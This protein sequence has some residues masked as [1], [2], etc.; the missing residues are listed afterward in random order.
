MKNRICVFDLETCNL[1]LDDTAP[2][3]IAAIILD[4]ESLEPI[5]SQTFNLL[6]RP[7]D[8]SK[9]N[10]KSLEICKK[11]LDVL[12]KA[13][14]QEIVFKHFA[15]FL[16]SNAISSRKPMSLPIPAGYNIVNFDLP[17]ISYLCNKYKTG[18]VFH[19]IHKLDALNMLYNLLEGDPNI[20]SLS[21]DN[22]RSLT[23]L[24]TNKDFYKK[25]AKVKYTHHDHDA[26]KDCLD[27]AQLIIRLVKYYRRL[28]FLDKFKDSFR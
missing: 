8:E 26:F 16:Q 22:I 6:M 19:P 2:V 28:N 18:P 9:V 11:S 15:K 17:I 14:G 20:K 24:G 5:V 12:R 25:F 1:N 21:F 4:G 13:P 27:E 7:L 3:Q 10:P 23:G